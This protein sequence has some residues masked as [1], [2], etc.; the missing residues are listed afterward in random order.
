MNIRKK[1]AEIVLLTLTVVMGGGFVYYSIFTDIK[2]TTQSVS[3]IYNQKPVSPTVQFENIKT[4]NGRSTHS[5]TRLND[6]NMPRTAATPLHKDVRMD[7]ITSDRGN[8]QYDYTSYRYSVKSNRNSDMYKGGGY[9]STE[10]L[11]YSSRGSKTGGKVVAQTAGGITLTEPGATSPFAVPKTPNGTPPSS[12]DGII[13]SDP[14][15]DPNENEMIPVGE[16]IWMLIL[17]IACYAGWISFVM[18]K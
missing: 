10:I 8:I 13:L 1:I 5:N 16:G 7:G 15:T 11:V 6:L 2:T 9:C 14:M 4:K 12:A 18:R 17:F 3:S